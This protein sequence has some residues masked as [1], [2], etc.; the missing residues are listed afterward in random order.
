VAGEKKAIKPK[1]RAPAVSAG[2]GSNISA[3]F[4]DVCGSIKKG[5]QNMTNSGSS[6]TSAVVLSA[7]DRAIDNFEQYFPDLTPAEKLK[8]K[9]A[10]R[11][12]KDNE[13]FL[14]LKGEEMGLFISEVLDT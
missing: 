5:V 8:F 2:G 9:K 12:S 13:M 6:P 4:A 3:M 1:A 14:K 11:D 7:Y 10:M